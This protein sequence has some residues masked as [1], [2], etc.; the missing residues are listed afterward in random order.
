MLTFKREIIFTH[1][2]WCRLCLHVDN[3]RHRAIY[4][5]KYDTLSSRSRVI[6]RRRAPLHIRSECAIFNYFR[7]RHFSRY[8]GI[9]F[10]YSFNRELPSLYHYFILQSPYFGFRHTRHRFRACAI[11]WS[12]ALPLLSIQALSRKVPLCLRFQHASWCRDASAARTQ[13]RVLTDME[14]RHVSLR[15]ISLS[16]YFHTIRRSIAASPIVAEVEAASLPKT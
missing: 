2:S 9:F 3:T 4:H 12:P 7:Q 11:S 8:R 10:I 6:K 1:S 14:R 13:Y 16:I 5:W 15:Q